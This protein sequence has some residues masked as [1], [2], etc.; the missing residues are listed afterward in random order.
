MKIFTRIIMLAAVIFGSAATGFAQIKTGDFKPVPVNDA[1]VVA[2]ADFAVVEQADKAEASIELIEIKKAERQ[3][4]AGTNFKLC[5]LVNIT[6]GSADE[7]Y[8]RFVNAVIFRSLKDEYSL[9]SW[10]ETG[11]CDAKL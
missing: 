1:E 11:D 7:P 2:A 3:T 5:I 4:V 6:D 9:K 10:T 8:E